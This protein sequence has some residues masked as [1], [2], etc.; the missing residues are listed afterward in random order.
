MGFLRRY[1]VIAFLPSLLLLAGCAAAQ[2]S[3]ANVEVRLLDAFGAF[4]VVNRGPAVS[5][6][7]EIGIEQKA[8]S[9]W[10]AIPVT[11][12]YLVAACDS[13]AKGK[14]SELAVGANLKPMPWR[15]WHC[16][17]QCPSSCRLDSAVPAG[18]YR[19][20]VMSCDRK[21]RFESKP[22]LKK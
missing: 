17:S 13:P 5:L 2:P 10:I 9:G 1:Q 15:G 11:N 20:V 14:C 21:Q 18:T 16:Y 3:G 4:E 8:D 6:A 19:F 22:F 12:F 7:S